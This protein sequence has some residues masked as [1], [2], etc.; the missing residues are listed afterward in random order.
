M[1]DFVRI[2]VFKFD[3]LLYI[4]I[5]SVVNLGVEIHL[6]MP[7]IVQIQDLLTEFKLSQ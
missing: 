1:V 5:F 2:D 7:E 4:D 3:I 6:L